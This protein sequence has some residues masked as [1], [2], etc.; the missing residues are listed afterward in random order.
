MN[1]L[2]QHTHLPPAPALHTHTHT[3]LYFMPVCLAVDSFREMW[4]R[5][6]NEPKLR[7]MMATVLNL[8]RAALTTLG[9]EALCLL[10][11]PFPLFRLWSVH[12]IDTCMVWPGRRE[13]PGRTDE[14]LDGLRAG[15]EERLGC[16]S[17][18]FSISC[19][20]SSLLV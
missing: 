9:L 1:V 4:L 16:A 11:S 12:A 6:A 19:V 8:A 3:H 15:P 18:G 10:W 20:V 14:E 13:T 2:Q 7:A 5:G 17:G